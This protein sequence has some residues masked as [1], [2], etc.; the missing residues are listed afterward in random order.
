VVIISFANLSREKIDRVC[1]I[2]AERG[3][4]VRRFRFSLEAVASHPRT[5]DVVMFKR[6]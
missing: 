2:C 6:G 5:A 4:E 3:V 1:E